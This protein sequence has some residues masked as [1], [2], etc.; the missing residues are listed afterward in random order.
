MDFSADNVLKGIQASG[1]ERSLLAG[2]LESQDYADQTKRAIVSDLTKFAAWFVEV[3]HEEFTTKRITKRD[4]ADF[5]RAMRQQR[6]QAVATVNRALV[7]IRKYLGYLV[8]E[9]HLEENLAEGVKE[10][11]KTQLAPQGLQRTEVRRLLRQAEAL[12]DCRA[13]AVFHLFCFTGIRVSE[14]AGLCRSDVKIGPRSGSITIRNGKG[15]K[16]RCVPLCKD[17]R[18]AIS[19]YLTVRPQSESDRLFMGK[20]G[21]LSSRAVRFV[22]DKYAKQL[23]LDFSPHLLRHTFA[24]AYLDQSSNDLVGLAAILG[25]ENLQT[26]RRYCQ[27]SAER[28]AQQ[29]E[30]LTY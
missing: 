18:E 15:N 14:L 27:P 26:T 9:G 21:P 17:A 20:R 22:C 16:E 19:K 29:T 8:K 25:H 28:L 13:S 24:K 2:F 3:N 1:T 23:G 10:L 30:L 12:R 5:R 7:S 11:R 6:Q 4:V